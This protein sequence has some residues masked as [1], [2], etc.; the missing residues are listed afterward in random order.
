MGT[1]YLS[2]AQYASLLSKSSNK[3]ALTSALTTASS[4]AA[5]Y[6]TV[7]TSSASSLAS[8]SLLMP[9]EENVQELSARLADKMNSLLKKSGIRSTP[10]IEISVDANTGK[11]KVNSDRADA[12]TIEAVL[13]A[14]KEVK[15]LAQTV[16]ALSSHTYDLNEQLQFQKEYR[17]SNNVEAV[18]AKYASLFGTQK[19]HTFSM[20]LDGS[21]MQV[22][23]DGKAWL[24]S[25]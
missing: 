16:N 14:N 18:I 13:N 22:L 17:A 25:T 2:S 9:T 24:K 21:R 1:T 6:D 15:Q 8:Q 11:I 7:Q 23:A 19:T 3:K 12:K 20:R 10:P 4:A 5:K